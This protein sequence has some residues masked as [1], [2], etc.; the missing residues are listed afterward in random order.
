[1]S[2]LTPDR[3]Q[4]AAALVGDSPASTKKSFTGMVPTILAGLMNLSSSDTGAGQLLSLVHDVGGDGNILND[5]G[6]LFSG[7]TTTQTAMN[8]GRDVLRVGIGLG[9]LI[10]G[11]LLVRAGLGGTPD[12]LEELL[13][14]GLVATLGGAIAILATTAR[15]DG[16]S[17]FEMETTTPHHS[18]HVAERQPPAP[19]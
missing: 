19:R 18:S 10:S 16:R 6:A 3:I 12:E 11:A 8:T 5:L 1:M 4:K 15:S 14:A 2:L 9:L 7:G 13:T 17:D